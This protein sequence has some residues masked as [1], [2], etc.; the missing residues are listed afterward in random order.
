MPRD[1]ER[2]V[3]SLQITLPSC[4]EK[5]RA[6]LKVWNK[7]WI[8]NFQLYSDHISGERIWA[9][10]DTSATFCLQDFIDIYSSGLSSFIK[11]VPCIIYIRLNPRCWCVI[12]IRAK[13]GNGNGPYAW[14]VELFRLGSG[15][16][17]SNIL[18]WIVYFWRKTTVSA[19]ILFWISGRL[20]AAEQHVFAIRARYFDYIK[21][22]FDQ[23]FKFYLRSSSCESASRMIW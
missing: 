21:L 1:D 16:S 10:R 18:N 3:A 13:K 6:D 8:K 20:S 22:K 4:F 11:I 9:F 12:W 5:I 19:E 14:W 7:S 15:I 17:M 23:F 2:S